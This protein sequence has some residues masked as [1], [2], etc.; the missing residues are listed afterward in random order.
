MTCA[1]LTGGLGLPLSR[2]QGPAVNVLVSVDAGTTHA[3]APDRSQAKDTRPDQAER[4]AAHDRST[5]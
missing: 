2:L 1:R 3:G 4:L 5:H